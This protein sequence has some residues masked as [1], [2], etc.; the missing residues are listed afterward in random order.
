MTPWAPKAP[1]D[2]RKGVWRDARKIGAPG[3][4]A[5]LKGCR[6]A[7]LK[8]PE[9]LSDRQQAGAARVA[10]VNRSLYRVYL[11]KDQLR[12]V[13]QLRGRPVIRA[14]DVW[15]AWAGRCQIP[16]FVDLCRKILR[17]RDS[18]IGTLTDDGPLHALVET[19]NKKQR[20]PTCMSYGFKSIKDLRDRQSHR[21][22][23][24]RSRW[25]PFAVTWPSGGKSDPRLSH[26][27]FKKLGPQ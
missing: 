17:H 16:A 20:L 3:L 12:L 6:H 24:A 22:V 5:H 1:D 11:L 25:L 19:T 26:E 15:C 9:N 18:I 2:V 21:T 14:L 13:L 10:A 4:I 7:L 8:N 23:C 27:S